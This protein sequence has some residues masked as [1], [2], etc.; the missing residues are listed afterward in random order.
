MS[1]IHNKRIKKVFAKLPFNKISRSILTRPFTVLIS[2]Q[3]FHTYTCKISFYII[4]KHPY[5]LCC[6]MS[7]V[8]I[9]FHS[10]PTAFAV[11]SCHIVILACCLVKQLR[12][13]TPVSRLTNRAT[14]IKCTHICKIHRHKRVA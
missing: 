4:I 5:I 10:N 11:F 6:F 1:L 14:R 3:L 9:V 7:L 12:V 2:A 13:R 8:S